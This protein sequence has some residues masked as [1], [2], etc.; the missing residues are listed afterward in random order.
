MFVQ[1]AAVQYL[2]NKMI[3]NLINVNNSQQDLEI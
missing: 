2:D 1:Q 3:F